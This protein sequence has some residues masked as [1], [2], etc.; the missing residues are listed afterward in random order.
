MIWALII[1]ILAG[2]AAFAI[3]YGMYMG[4]KAAHTKD[5]ATVTADREATRSAFGATE[6]TL[7]SERRARADEKSRLED[8]ITKLR[9]EI[10]HLET[11]L[12][13]CADPDAV[14]ARLR[15]LLNP[16]S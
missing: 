12:Q 2:V 9:Q 6:R 7:A 1:A 4:E 8:E 13:A 11:D 14:R 15:R 10:A 16:V 5:V 3:V